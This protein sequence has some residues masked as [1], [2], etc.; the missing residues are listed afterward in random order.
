MFTS[1]VYFHAIGVLHLNTFSIT[2][3]LQFNTFDVTDILNYHSFD[4]IY[5]IGVPDSTTFDVSLMICLIRN[6]KSISQPIN[7]F[8]KLPLPVE[9][10]PGA[11]L[12]RIK[13]FRNILAHPHKMAA[14][15][16]NTAWSNISDVSVS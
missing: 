13:W 15:D 5:F 4:T 14:V 7:G 1:C 10:T 8:D 11:D 3:V 2:D 9:T 16:F 12:A 6:L